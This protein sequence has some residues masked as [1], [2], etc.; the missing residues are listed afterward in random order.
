MI[1]TGGGHTLGEQ[2]DGMPPKVVLIWL[3]AVSGNLVK[4]ERFK[5]L[6]SRVFGVADPSGPLRK[7]CSR[8]DPEAQV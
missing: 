3:W 5:A 4:Q 1:P 7:P 8:L 6:G 2:G